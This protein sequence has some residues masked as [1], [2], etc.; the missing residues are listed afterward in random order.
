MTD[1]LSDVRLQRP[2]KEANIWP[3]LGLVCL[4]E[5][6]KTRQTLSDFDVGRHWPTFSLFPQSPLCTATI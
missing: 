5:G 1:G 4:G 2:S 6:Q 3:D